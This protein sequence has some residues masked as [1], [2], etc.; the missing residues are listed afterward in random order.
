[1]LS[2]DSNGQNDAPGG[3]LLGEARRVWESAL[4]AADAEKLTAAAL[5]RRRWKLAAGEKRYDLR[6]F[7]RVLLCAFGKAAPAMARGAMSVLGDKVAE[8]I[9]VGPALD[10][11]ET[12]GADK[13]RFLPAAHP[14]PDERSVRAAEALLDLARNAGPEDL[15]VVL[16]SGGGSAQAALPVPGISLDEERALTD[17]LLRAGAGIQELNAVRRRLSAFKGG[18]L[19][20]AAFPASVLSL[21]LSDVIGNDLSVIASGPTVLDSSDPAE[22]K[23]VLMKYKLWDET[24]PAVRRVLDEA[25]AIHDPAPDPGFEQVVNVVVGDNR[26]ALEAAKKQAEKLGFRV[27]VLTASDHGEAREAARR[28]AAL[29]EILSVQMSARRPVCLLAGGELTVTVR[30]PGRGGRNQEFVLASLVEMGRRFR[31]RGEWIIASLG[32]DGIDGT[33]A[34]AGAWA[35]P[36]IAERA[37]VQSLDAAA[38]LDAND[39]YGFFERTGGLIV[40]GPT[41]TNVMD[42]RLLLYAPP[43]KKRSRFGAR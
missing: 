9:V 3:G 30:G 10:A 39:S 22:A 33:T 41:R 8:G 6:R 42:L 2:N 16:I 23:N 38:F 4:A 7:R 27:F 35:S 32:T 19:A 11:A 1:M 17:G 34:A 36:E 28:Y 43:E 37:A 14:L 15:L 24:S 25:G 18:K 26:I 29:L 13:L 20:R 12:P 5:V 21:V 40:T 31:G